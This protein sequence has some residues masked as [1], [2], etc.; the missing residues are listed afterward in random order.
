MHHAVV[1]EWQTLQRQTCLELERRA[2][3]GTHGL[4]AIGFHRV[5]CAC[6]EDPSDLGGV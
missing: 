4:E 6:S 3:R 5:I 1:A 2:G